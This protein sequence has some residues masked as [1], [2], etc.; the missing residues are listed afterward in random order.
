MLA[1]LLFFVLPAGA[2]DT[3]FVVDKIIAKVDNYIVLK[4][5][6]EIGYQAYLSEGNP[7]SEEARC[8]LFNRLIL[9]KLMVAKAEIDSVVVLDLEVDN[10]TEQRMAMI[11][12][13]SGNS[14]EQLERVYGK[15]MEQIKLELRDQ[16]RE[17]LIAREMTSRITKGLTV[18]PAEIKK[19]YNKIPQDSLPFYSSDVEVAQIVRIAKVSASQEDEARKK[20]LDLRERILKGE[21]FAELAM[22]NSE[23]PSAQYNGGDLGYVGRGAMVPQFEAMAFRL[24]VGEISQPFKSDFGFH[25]LQLLDRRGNEYHSRHILISAV[26]SKEDIALAEKYLDSLRSK[27]IIDKLNFEQ[28]AKEYSDDEM[29]KGMGGFFTDGDGSTKISMRDID[30]VVYLNI[31][32]MKVGN[33]SKPLQYRTDDGK[34]A[35]RILY[36]KKKLPPHAANL[37]D[38]WNRIQSAALAEKK[39]K[40]LDKWFIKARQDVFINIDPT[41]SYCKI[42]E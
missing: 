3:G 24:K 18:T 23:D 10:N 32:T 12:Q 39:D 15:S 7:A 28:I 33:I 35:V 27:I 2:Q 6:L 41:Y 30:P 42:M 20:L 9:N 31:D 29:T 5:E 17:Q 1:G 22:K 38:D 34:D 8:E 21:S 13:S 4:S 37:K 36:F 16:I 40:A 14:P 25:I 11:L 26:P 19:F